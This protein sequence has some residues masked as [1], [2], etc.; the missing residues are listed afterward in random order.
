MGI[1]YLPPIELGLDLICDEVKLWNGF[2]LVTGQRIL[3]HK[4]YYTYMGRDWGSQA[5][6]FLGASGDYY[7]MAATEFAIRLSNGEVC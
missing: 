7:H 2:K 6:I 1:R 4:Q 5:L 3:L